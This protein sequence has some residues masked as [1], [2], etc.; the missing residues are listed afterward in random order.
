MSFSCLVLRTLVLIS[1]VAVTVW[2][3]SLLCKNYTSMDTIHKKSQINL[4]EIVT[5]MMVFCKDPPTNDPM[6]DLITVYYPERSYFPL[7]NLTITKMKT[8]FKV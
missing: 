2:Q 6:N 3:A 1:C 4:G 7:G 8:M 5:P